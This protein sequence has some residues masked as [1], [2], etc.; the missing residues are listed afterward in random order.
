MAFEIFLGA[1]QASS[2]LLCM[3]LTEAWRAGR[4]SAQLHVRVAPDVVHGLAQGKQR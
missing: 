1:M 4:G 2:L 3:K